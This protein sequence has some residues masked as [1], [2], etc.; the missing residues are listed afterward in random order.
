M[1]TKVDQSKLLRD[2]LLELRDKK[3]KLNAL[4]KLIQNPL[5]LLVL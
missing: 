3:A 5:P 1:T 4:D 2:A